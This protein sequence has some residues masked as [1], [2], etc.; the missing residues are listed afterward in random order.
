MKKKVSSKLKY[1]KETPEARYKRVSS[2]V[3]FRAVVFEDRRR[4][5]MRKAI[6]SEER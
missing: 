3:K 4:K 5:L 2:G 6:E 1:V